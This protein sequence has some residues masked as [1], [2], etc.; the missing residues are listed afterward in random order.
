[1]KLMPIIQLLS[2]KWIK[3]SNTTTTHRFNH[4]TAIIHMNLC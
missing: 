4:F 1:M 2:Q 3:Y